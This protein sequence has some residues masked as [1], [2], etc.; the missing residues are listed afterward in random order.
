MQAP[1][2]SDWKLPLDVLD[3]GDPAVMLA[4]RIA[5]EI[6]RFVAPGSAERVHDE[7]RGGLRPVTPGDVMILVRTR[8]AFFEAMI[9]A[10]KER[11]VPVMPAPT[12]S[13]SRSILPSWTSSRR[14]A[15]AFCRRTI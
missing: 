9:R 8:G 13:S 11:N 1:L 10:L 12:G 7:S 4:R 14:G 2:A 6:A 3:E 5:T 15:P